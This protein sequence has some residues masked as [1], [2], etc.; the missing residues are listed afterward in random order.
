MNVSFFFGGGGF[1]DRALE[2]GLPFSEQAAEKVEVPTVVPVVE[3]PEA[4]SDVQPVVAES[5]AGS[6]DSGE[7][8]KKKGG[9]G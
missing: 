1:T 8:G 9:G 3:S 4:P 2:A 5:S 7:C 6:A